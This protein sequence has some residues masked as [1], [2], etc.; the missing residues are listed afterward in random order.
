MCDNNLIDILLY[1][2]SIGV[3]TFHT[4]K[5]LGYSKTFVMAGTIF[6]SIQSPF[7]L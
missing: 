1:L 6:V 2:G 3:V 4:N 5:Y 7:L